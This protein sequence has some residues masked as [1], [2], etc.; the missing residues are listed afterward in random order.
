MSDV[1]DPDFYL[2]HAGYVRALA[3]RLVYD[4]HAADDLFQAAWLAALQRPPRDGSTPRRWLARIVRNLASKLWLGDRRRQQRERRSM[5]PPEP[6]SPDAVLAHE[7]ERRRLVAA[8]LALDEPYRAT[9]IA[10]FFDGLSAEQIAA[11]DGLSVETVRTRQKRGLQRLR[12]RLL[13][14][15]P[16]AGALVHGLGLGGPGM[17]AV[18]GRVVQGV[19]IMNTKQWL[20]SFGLLV[21]LA[22]GWFVLPML[23]PRP[24]SP[25]PSAPVAATSAVDAPAPAAAPETTAPPPSREVAAPANATSVTTGSLQVRVQWAD[26]RPASDVGVRV[27]FAAAPNPEAHAVAGR[28]DRVGRVRFDDVLAGEAW[29]E[30]D[31]GAFATCTIQPGRRSDAVLTIAPGVRIRGRVQDVDGRPAV[32]A[33]VSML[34][35]LQPYAGHVVAVADADGAFTI[36]DAPAE[37]TLLLSA[38]AAGRAPTPQAVVQARAG[39]VVDC[40]LQ[41][42]ARGGAVGGRVVDVAGA[43]VVGATVVLGP[44]FGLDGAKAR[45]A[46]VA[47][48]PPLRSRR[49]ATDAHGDWRVDGVAAGDT[50][51]LV[52]A[53][54]LAPWTGQ[55]FVVEG[56]LVRC[57]TVMSPAVQVHGTVR[58]E[59]GALLAAATVRVGRTPLQ[60]WAVRSDAAGEFVLHGLPASA[61]EAIA[62][63]EGAGEARSTLAGSA[64][65]SLRWDPVLVLATTLRGRVLAANA[66]VAKARVAARCMSTA[67]RPWFAEAT[68]EADG[69]FQIP[70]CPDGLLHLDVRTETSGH[71]TVCRRDDV[72]P[73]GGEVL[74]EVD[75]ARMP[76]SSVVGRVV[77]ADGTPIDG[78]EVTVLRPDHEWGGGHTLRSGPDGRFRSHLVPPGAWYLLVRADGLAQLSVPAR[79]LPANASE[80]F[81]DLVL[82]AGSS[83]VVTLQPDGGLAADDCVVGIADAVTG[84]A[85]ERPV[86]G[87]VRFARLAPGD[88]T[89]TAYAPGVALRPMTVTVGAEGE[90]T[91]ALRLHA[92]IEVVV[93]V[94]DEH[95]QPF[96]GRLETELRDGKGMRLD[97]TPLDPT[98]GPLRWVRRLVADRYEL[99]LRDHRGRS[100]V[101]PFTVAADR[102]SLQL[103]VRFP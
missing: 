80:D 81:G 30:S 46:G 13:P 25:A 70:N 93:D 50:E 31:R 94:R 88:Y 66:P 54:R 82:T 86:Q 79:A 26:Q 57:D 40:E 101:V 15:G 12:E 63:K 9:L 36:D 52:L 56:A 35:R 43:P 18:L 20:L 16:A 91:F 47:S 34:V 71:F 55:A 21:L 41:F 1:H 100:L 32:G 11:R 58:D 90:T 6:S 42:A 45:A 78:A 68:T 97:A 62:S 95:G 72:D 5:P 76:S 7:Q 51:L 65:A 69:R 38:F 103:T 2:A 19:T 74:L 64:G 22:T 8:L 59:R 102:D 61:F 96:G 60:T 89:L 87:V 67:Q 83:L 84:L 73:R 99:R 29:I 3:R 10:R 77:A 33:Q 39:E 75:A 4:P 98:G 37:R 24:S 23:L 28:T 53:P 14:G 85:S 92:G 17:R 49:T 48:L 44:E 27:G